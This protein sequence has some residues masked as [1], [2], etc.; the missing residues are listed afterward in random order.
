MGEVY[1]ATDSHLKRSIAIA[2]DGQRFLVHA[3]VG[4]A[5]TPLDVIVNWPGPLTQRSEAA[6][7]K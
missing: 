1:R 7:P 4:N 2:P 5:Q 3:D 6:A